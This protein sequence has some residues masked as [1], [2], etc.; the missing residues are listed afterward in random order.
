MNCTSIENLTLRPLSAEE[1]RDVYEKW[2][3][4]QF[5]ANELKP[6]SA[7]ERLRA[8]DEYEVYGLWDG[9]ALIAYAFFGK[10]SGGS[11]LLLDYY[12]VLPQYQDC[13][14]GG[15]FLNL[16]RRDLSDLEAIILEVEN[17]EFVADPQEREIA[18]RRV[19]FYE[20]N[21]CV[22]TDIQVK[23]FGLE[24][25]IMVLPLRE[26]LTD[27]AVCARLAEIYHAFF[28]QDIYERHVHLRRTGA[29]KQTEE[30]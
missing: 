1:T 16:L 14:Y 26:R 28:P 25:A 11:S 29:G 10:A 7:V 3:T 12:A 27:D 13:G 2:M 17:P 30:V 18:V 19:R 6:L 21:A 5:H 22:H 15:A 23:L 24:Y 9:E 4:T 20:R 8:R